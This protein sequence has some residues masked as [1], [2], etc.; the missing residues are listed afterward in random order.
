MTLSFAY[1]CETIADYRKALHELGKDDTKANGVKNRLF[2]FQVL[3]FNI[4]NLIGPGTVIYICYHNFT[5]LVN[6]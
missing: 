6:I 5:K 2:A 3:G 1:I 4:G